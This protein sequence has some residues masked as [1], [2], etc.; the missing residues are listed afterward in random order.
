MWVGRKRSEGKGTSEKENR[1]DKGKMI[2]Q[3][4]QKKK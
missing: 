2:D 1:V 3:I 4:V